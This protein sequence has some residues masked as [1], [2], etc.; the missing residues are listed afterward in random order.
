MRLTQKKIMKEKT[1]NKNQKIIK[2]V[3]V[4][5]GETG[6]VKMIRHAKKH[7]INTSNETEARKY[8]SDAEARKAIDTLIEMGEGRTNIFSVVESQMLD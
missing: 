6:Y 8:R 5:S 3:N 7:F 4:Y 1:T 2:W